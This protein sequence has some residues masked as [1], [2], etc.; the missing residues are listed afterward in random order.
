MQKIPKLSRISPKKI[1]PLKGGSKKLLKSNIKAV[2][3]ALISI[4]GLGVFHKELLPAVNLLSDYLASVI[5]RGPTVPGS[6]IKVHDGD[7][8]TMTGE[9]EDIRIRLYGIDAPEL[10]QEYGETA[11]DYLAS[12][13]EG[14]T[15]ALEI[16]EIDRYGRNVGLITAD[17]ESVNLEMLKSGNA[18]FYGSYC[19]KYFCRKWEAA[20]E[21]AKR[22]KKG[23]WK[24]GEPDPP[25]KYRR[26]KG[27]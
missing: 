13:I 24:E 23:F 17:N 19:K 7:T 2:I 4:F 26:Q 11:R 14:K 12:L 15:V 6:V 10:S 1:T 8:F 16:T 5:L 9:K 27:S 22:E 3:I 21:S 20:A 18:W 25:W